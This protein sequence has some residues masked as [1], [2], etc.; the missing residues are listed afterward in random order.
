VVRSGPVLAFLPRD[1]LYLPAPPSYLIPGLL[2]TGL[3][4]CFFCAF[5]FLVECAGGGFF[6]AA[7]IAGLGMGMGMGMGGCAQFFFLGGLGG[8]GWGVV[9]AWVWRV[10]VAGLW[11]GWGSAALRGLET[12]GRVKRG[13]PGFAVCVLELLAQSYM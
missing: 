6:L 9:A 8:A 13:A 1:T 3:P 7:Q 4:D 10:S 2:A 5:Y 11:L 12:E